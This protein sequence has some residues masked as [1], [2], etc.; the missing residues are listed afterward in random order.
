METN[1]VARHPDKEEIIK[2]LLNGESVKQI[3]AWLKKK[4]PRTKRLHI[5]YMTLQKF[6]SENLNI[7]GDLLEDIKLKKKTDELVSADAELKLAVSNSSEYQKKINE[8]VSNEMDVQR[9]LLEMEKLI[10]S[11]MEFYYNTVAAGGNIKHDRLF[12][13]YLN[14]MRSIMQDWKKYIEGFADKKIEHN[15]NV[16]IVNDQIN[17][18]KEVVIDVLRDMDPALVL[19]FMEKLNYRMTGLKHDSPEYN[20]YLIEVS[21]A[22]EV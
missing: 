14:M 10:S 1:K 6:R 15:L 17:I 21:D 7:K 4:Y 11:R 20:Q 9:K 3:E 8:I 16:N 2:M 12:L 13:E 19:I 5:S 22:E 18:M